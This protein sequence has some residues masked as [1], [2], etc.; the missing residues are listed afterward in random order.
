IGRSPGR[1]VLNLPGEE[2]VTAILG[3]KSVAS[4][5]WTETGV[6]RFAVALDTADIVLSEGTLSLSDFTLNLSNQDPDESAY[7]L[8]VDAARTTLPDVL[9]DAA[10]LG[11][12]IDKIQLRV[13]VDNADSFINRNRF[14]RQPNTLMDTEVSLAQ[15][16]VD[17][18]PVELGAKGNALL[19]YSDCLPDGV[20]N[21][22]LENSDRLIDALKGAGELTDEIE[23]GIQA[24]GNISDSGSFVPITFSGGAVTFLGQAVADIPSLCWEAPPP[25]SN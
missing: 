18:G 1:N 22:R 4:L 2:P 5:S 7:R 8:T 20:I 15:L 10:W 25:P 6:E 11:D 17:W 3:S 19:E 9:A 16:L 21:I 14:W 24:I 12:T 13:D 23:T